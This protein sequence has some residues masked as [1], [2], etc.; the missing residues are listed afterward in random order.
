LAKIAVRTLWTAPHQI[1]VEF[2]F[3]GVPQ[4]YADQKKQVIGGP[5]LEAPKLEGPHGENLTSLYGQ[6]A[7]GHE[8]R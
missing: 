8:Q 2:F 4:K 5:S 3:Q 7:H 1:L 6:S